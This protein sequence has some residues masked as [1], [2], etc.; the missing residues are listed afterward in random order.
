VNKLN[1]DADALLQFTVKHPNAVI[2]TEDKC[3]QLYR[4]EQWLW[5]HCTVLQESPLL[6]T[7]PYDAVA[8]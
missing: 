8:C 5:H 4:I 2:A 3:S 6:L 7:D 1:K